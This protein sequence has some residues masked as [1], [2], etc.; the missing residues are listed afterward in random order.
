MPAGS[1]V[2]VTWSGPGAWEHFIEIVPAGASADAAPLTETRTSQGSPLQI[3]APAQPG[4]YEIRYRMRDLG[5]VLI[6]IPLSVK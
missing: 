5:D 3:F 4:D 6:A 2:E 1:V